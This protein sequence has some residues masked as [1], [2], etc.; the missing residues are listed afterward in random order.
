MSSVDI[1]VKKRVPSTP[2]S[3]QTDRVRLRFF[4]VI[5]GFYTPDSGTVE[6]QGKDITGFPSYKIGRAGISRTFQTLCLFKNMSVHDNV[7]V[8]QQRNSKYPLLPNMFPNEKAAGL[9]KKELGGKSPG[10]SFLHGAFQRAG[11]A[12]R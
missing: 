7:I 5:T 8:G 12:S 1:A 9:G 6:F 2:S 10:V 11:H 4:N 3:A